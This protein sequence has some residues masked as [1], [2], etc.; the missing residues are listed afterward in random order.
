MTTHDTPEA[1]LAAALRADWPCICT[2]IW[3][4]RGLSDPD[5][6]HHDPEADAAD[7]IAAL[8][9]WTLVPRVATAD[10]TG[11]TKRADAEEA[12]LRAALAEIA[13]GHPLESV[14][15]CFCLSHDTALAALA[16]SE[17]RYTADELADLA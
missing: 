15:P 4:E 17:P 7:L 5:C 16:P 8:D 9:D 3:T 10:W 14:D 1:T 6:P 11:S 2:P 13:E 12:R